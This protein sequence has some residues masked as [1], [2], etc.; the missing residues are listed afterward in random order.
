MTEAEI[1]SIIEKATELKNLANSKVDYHI[2]Y[3]A[4]PNL[5]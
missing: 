2:I 5:Q 4:R 1:N 3:P